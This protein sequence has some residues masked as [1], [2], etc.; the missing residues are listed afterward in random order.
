MT[1]RPRGTPDDPLRMCLD[2]N[3][4]VARLLAQQ[5][6]RTNTAPQVLID[7]VRRGDSSLGPVQLIIS[8]GMLNRL[9]KVLV[10]DLGAEARAVDLLIQ[11]IVAYAQRGPSR[12]APFL[13]LGGTGVIPARD[14]ED[15]HVLEA[16]IAGRTDLLVTRNFRDF[17][18]RDAQVVVPDEVVLLPRTEG[19]AMVVAT[20]RWAMQWLHA[21]AITLP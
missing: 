15:G 3:L 18:I 21:G 6:G 2:L 17:R 19:G 14:E 7:V 1:H 11:T 4:W 20:P 9:T 5:A 13:L 10:Q 12:T 8:W 16:A